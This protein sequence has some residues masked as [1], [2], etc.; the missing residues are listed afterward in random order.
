MFSAKRISDTMAKNLYGTLRHTHAR[1]HAHTHI[2]PFV[3]TM[4]ISQMH[5]CM[6]TNKH[7]TFSMLK[8]GNLLTKQPALNCAHPTFE[9]ART[10]TQQHT[11]Q[12]HTQ[13]QQGT[14][15]TLLKGNNTSH[16]QHCAHV[17]LF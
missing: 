7:S 16:I 8:I 15:D 6:Q 10:F 11:Q 2:C 12:Q 1:T 9:F 5:A 4:A 14:R 3:P 17:Q 13:L